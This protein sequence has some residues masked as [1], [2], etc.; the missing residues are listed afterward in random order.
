[1]VS[2]NASAR[3]APRFTRTTLAPS[4]ANRMAVAVP[5]PIPSPRG[6]APVTMATLPA[7]RFMGRLE[8]LLHSF[9]DGRVLRWGAGTEG[10]D[11]FAVG[12]DQDLVEVPHR[13]GG[14]PQL[15]LGP[16]VEW[17]AR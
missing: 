3:S 12:A 17:V 4:R 11:G 1:M 8:R 9:D 10:G 15:F 6:A 13:H 16:G 2:A 14:R 7:R 5:L